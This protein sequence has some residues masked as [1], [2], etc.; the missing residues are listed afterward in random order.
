MLEESEQ[1]CVNGMDLFINRHKPASEK[2][3]D[4]SHLLA[5]IFKDLYTT[6]II[7][8]E[9]VANLTKS[10]TKKNPHHAKYVEAL[11]QVNLDYNKRIQD[12]D[13]LLKHIIQA[14]MNAS[15]K[16]EQ[17]QSQ[18]MEE[19][20]E[21]YHQ[22]G[23]PPVKSTL[24]WCVDNGLLKRHNLICPQEYIKE[25]V[26]F[27]KAPQEKSEP[28]YTQPTVSYKMH[29]STKPQDDGY[30]LMPKPVTAQSLQ[31]ESEEAFTLSS[32]QGTLFGQNNA[33]QKVCPLSK[34]LRKEKPSLED[35]DALRK[36]KRYQNFLRN[37]HFQPTS[38]Q[39]GG[40]SLIIPKR[41]V[42]KG[43]K[44]NK[45]SSS[46]ED[47][48]P[49]FMANPPVVL[50]TDYQIGEVYETTVE[51][52]NMTAASRHVRV[53]PPTTPHFS[54]GLGRFPDGRGVIAPGMS[55]QYTVRFAPD[56]LAE[57][58]DF[59]V[60]ETQTSHPMI[61]P[62]EARRPPPV[63][64]LPAVLDLGYCLVG[65][66]KHMNLLCRN[67]G[68][69]A[70]TFCIMPKG[71][72][73]ASSLRSVVKS[74]FAEEPP[75][76]ISP[77]L[78][79]LLPGQVEVMQVVFFPTTAENFTRSFSIVC[80]NCHVKN[81]SMQGTGQ[82]VMLELVAVEGGE[83]V[84]ALGELRD[85]TAEHFIRFEPTN[86]HSV[87]QKKVLIRNNT[88]L[89]LPFRWRIMKPNLQCLHAAQQSDPV[90]DVIAME[91]EV[92]GSTEPYR[93]LLEPYAL[94]VPGETY[95]HT[96]IRKGFKMWNHSKSAISFQWERI[97]DCHSVEVEPSLGKI[98]TNECFDL[99]L[100]L[101]GGRPGCLSTMLQCYVQHHTD[102]VNL[103]IEAT[104]KGPELSV[105]V[106]SVDLGLLQLGQE[107]CTTL[108]ISNST[109]LEAQWSLEEL[110]TDPALN[111][112]QVVDQG[113]V[114]VKPS[115]GVLPPMSSCS[116]NM[117]FR[118]MCCQSFE[119]VL[120]L[121][122]LNGTGCHL[123]VRA[124]VQRPQLCL[125]SSQMVLP[126]LYVGVAH[127]G[128]ATLFNQTLLP[129]HFTWRQQ[130]QGAQA[131]L[132]S[133]S[134][135]PSSGTLGPNEHM[136]ISVSFTTHTDVSLVHMSILKKH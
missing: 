49:I 106:P 59:L 125:L 84:P 20:G 130:L 69:S 92:K 123:P 132:C 48:V 19:V 107:V 119:S 39:R 27:Y 26:P 70:G 99:D 13:L 45:E 47:P 17:V 112:G 29:V 37:P 56:S 129:A 93:I 22:L 10:Y 127:N 75:F 34:Q 60:V 41:K 109:P 78:F 131:H 116:V 62:V 25:Q 44:G 68:F 52:R 57:F 121:A 91:L 21:S 110:P 31:E 15:V 104:F 61:L 12:A 79:S 94:F 18:L 43:E 105:R 85:L 46:S 64:T 1:K 100:V 53:I 3:Q 58:E 86:V 77:S 128:K 28:G 33:S 36:F 5:S 120:Q 16:E 14:R 134:F 67:D 101:T 114:S 38:H 23:L 82:V 80:D 50:F 124:E 83:D 88:H 6:E 135:T 90:S 2:T 133:A 87:L 74:C 71:Q 51:L 40:K 103:P 122:V 7:G 111:Q 126:D 118:A 89:E 8:K 73:P 97:S 9:T 24:M 72:W 76:A 32:S 102:P 136:E 55:C 4:I 81:F 42:E 108:Q 54:I 11:Q 30:T 63:L 35:S 98:E 113:Q 117:L 65:G 66:V 95:I 115:Q 96:T